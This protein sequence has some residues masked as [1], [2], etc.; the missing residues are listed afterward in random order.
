[1]KSEKTLA[2]AAG[3]GLLVGLRTFGAPAVLSRASRRGLISPHSRLGFLSSPRAARLLTVAAAGEM[4]ADKLPFM[5]SRLQPGS[6]AARAVSGAMCGATMAAQE[7]D[8][9]EIL[10]AAAI[11]GTAAIG[12]AY[13]G[14]HLRRTLARRFPAASL[15]VAMCEDSIA[16]GGALAIMSYAVRGKRRAKAA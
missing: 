6:L 4:I 10:I 7:T 12:G 9:A 8:D 5:V 3:I 14:H 2:L 11:A 13:V 15:A 1:M 16:I